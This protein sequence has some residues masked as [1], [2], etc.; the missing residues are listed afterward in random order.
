MSRCEIKGTS[1]SKNLQIRI[2]ES[3]TERVLVSL[4]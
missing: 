2:H 4:Y 1:E 3:K